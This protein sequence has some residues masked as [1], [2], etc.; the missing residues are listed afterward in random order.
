MRH[1]QHIQPKLQ[2]S[3]VIALLS[4]AVTMVAISAFSY[5][6]IKLAIGA[7]SQQIGLFYSTNGMW[8]SPGA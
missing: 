8:M 1:S 2:L 3:S 5:S 6:L 7:L 4:Y